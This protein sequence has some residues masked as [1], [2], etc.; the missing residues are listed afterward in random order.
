MAST[1]APYGLR[2]VRSLIGGGYVSGNT[3]QY[4]VT[5][6][7]GTSIFYGDIVNLDAN[8][9]II[10][11]TSTADMV[12]AVGVFLGCEY[13]DPNLNYKLHRNMWLAST[14]ATDVVAYV[15]DDPYMI[16]QA[17][18]DTTMAQTGLGLNY[19]IVQTAGNT[20]IGVSKVAVDG[21]TGATTNTLPVRVIGF[22]DGPDSAVGDAYTDVL[23]MINS[24]INRH[25]NSQGL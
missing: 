12:N 24:G 13:T 23:I 22:V 20:A 19:A 7:Y 21:D 4:K 25:L 18:S 5:N 15:C 11:S 6:S 3:R 10:K 1:A 17:Q 14:V 16:Y 9:L 8:G 2:P